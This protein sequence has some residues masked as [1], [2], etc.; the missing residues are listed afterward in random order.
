MTAPPLIRGPSNPD[1]FR[2]SVHGARWYKDTLPADGKWSPMEEAV[3]AV[4]TLKKAWSKPFRKKAPT[5]VTVPLDAYRAAE[6]AMGNLAEL[7]EMHPE[8]AFGMIATAP[9]RDL[10]RAADRGTALHTV[11]EAYAIGQQ[12]AVQLLDEPVK[13]FIAACEAFVAEWRPVWRMTEVIVINRAIGFAGTADAVVELPGLGLVI[14]DWKSRG[15]GHGAYP[16]E[17]CQLGGYA[18]ADYFV[19]ADPYSGKLER[20]DPPAFDAGAIVSMTADDGYRVYPVDMGKARRAFLGL[21]ETWRIRRAGEMEARQAIGLPLTKPEVTPAGTEQRED[22]QERGGAHLLQ[23]VGVD[24]PT[25]HAPDGPPHHPEEKEVHHPGG[26]SNSP[27]EGR[28]QDIGP[29]DSHHGRDGVGRQVGAGTRHGDHQDGEQQRQA[30][31]EGFQHLASSVSDSGP[32]VSGGRP[33]STSGLGGD[34][35][36]E[37]SEGDQGERERLRQRVVQIAGVLGEREL[38]I[39]WPPGVP[40]FQNASTY[41]A[42]ELFLIDQW[43]WG[44]ESLL[45]L[46][47]P[48][49]PQDGGGPGATGAEANEDQGGQE[50]DQERDPQGGQGS[51][52]HPLDD[53]HGGWASKGKALLSLLEDDQLARACASLAHCD[54]VRMTRVHYLALQAVVTQVGDP[55]G[56]VFAYWSG[57]GVEIR[58]VD[59]LETALIAAMPVDGYDVK[60]KQSKR[61]ALRRARNVAKRLAVPAPRSY[62][63]LCDDLL[64]ACC[65][66]VGHGVYDA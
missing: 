23:P 53:S 47:F 1:I 64:L 54:A 61:E 41:T 52:P 60:G 31:N 65:V 34:D 49:D 29:E 62:E 26:R 63:Q 9:E 12:P 6:Y 50:A 40:T 4:T 55:T 17:A 36:H 10:S 46:P 28:D 58:P 39:P 8:H 24:A 57:R 56:I 32:V 45:G 20:I 43:C 5:G 35:A 33:A 27:P 48:L 42:G 3:P 15:S 22:Q 11:M 25:P 37:S 18:S 44:M 7:S 38:P 2:V 66:A 16:E 19:V 21:F 30:E 51:E 59:D 14:V 13:P